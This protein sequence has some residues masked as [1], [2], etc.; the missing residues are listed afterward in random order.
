MTTRYLRTTKSTSGPRRRAKPALLGR[1]AR[2]GGSAR[3]GAARRAARRAAAL[4]GALPGPRPVPRPAHSC[5][6]GSPGSTSAIVATP[7]SS[8]DQ[9]QGGL[10]RPVAV[11]TASFRAWGR[12]QLRAAMTGYAAGPSTRAT[13][14][15]P[16]GDA[17]GDASGAAPDGRAPP[18][19]FHPLRRDPCY[20][21]Y[22]EALACEPRSR[23]AEPPGAARSSRERPCRSRAR[24]CARHALC[25][26]PT[27]SA[28]PRAPRRPTPPPPPQPPRPTPPGLDANNYDRAFCVEAFTAFKDCRAA[29]VGAEG[30][31]LRCWA[32]RA[33]RRGP[34][35]PPPPA[36]ARGSRGVATS[37]AVPTHATRAPPSPWAPCR[38]RRTRSGRR[39]GR[40]GTR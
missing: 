11:A 19:G 35:P 38:R 15:V 14:G 32:A 29:Q 33:P 28:P 26:T 3:R 18:L 31:P 25:S 1:G 24:G 10:A 2:R 36:Q 17:A 7:A 9:G 37:A 8:G 16:G 6:S 4:E 30:A 5:S 34:P 21:A 20:P 40:S 27:G 39:R 13:G 12:A 22:A 23:G